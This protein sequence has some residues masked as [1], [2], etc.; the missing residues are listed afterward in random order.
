MHYRKKKGILMSK[1]HDRLT[2]VDKNVDK[3]TDAILTYDLLRVKINS[4]VMVNYE[5]DTDDSN[6][7]T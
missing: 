6:S 7:G 4:P 3:L 2:F 1:T 5:N